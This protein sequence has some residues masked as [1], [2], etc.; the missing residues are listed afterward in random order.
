MSLVPTYYLPTSQGCITGY[1]GS[2]FGR[3]RWFFI[4]ACLTSQYS[5][6]LPTD[7]STY[8]LSPLPPTIQSPD[9][10]PE[11]IEVPP[12]PSGWGGA[13]LNISDFKYKY[14][15]SY[16]TYYLPTYLSIYLSTYL[17]PSPLPPDINA[18]PLTLSNIFSLKTAYHVPLPI[19][20][21]TY[22]PNESVWS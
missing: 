20:L 3:E 6:Y 5:T 15:A 10:F 13:R 17:I 2:P 4:H 11:G 19:Y 16:A 12:E 1:L 18:L 7:R 14:V 21:P 9:A 22:L 8:R